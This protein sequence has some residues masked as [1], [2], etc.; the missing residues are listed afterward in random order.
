NSYSLSGKLLYNLSIY[1]IVHKYTYSECICYKRR[2]LAVELCFKIFKCKTKVIIV[3]VEELSVVRLCGKKT[4]FHKSKIEGL[5]MMKN[6][7]N[8]Y[9][10]H[11]KNATLKHGIIKVL[12][13]AFCNTMML[14]S[15]LLIG[16]KNY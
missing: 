14:K 12:N 2:C 6:E 15:V 4:Y 11:I 3:L 5:L 8:H 7:F 16:K 1:L 13:D 9:I 10:E